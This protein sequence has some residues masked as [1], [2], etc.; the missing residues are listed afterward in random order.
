MNT[1]AP[2]QALINRRRSASF[3]SKADE[4]VNGLGFEG[5]RRPLRRRPAAGDGAE[6]GEDNR[7]EGGPQAYASKSIES[8]PSLLRSRTLS[9]ARQSVNGARGVSA[10]PTESA[11]SHVVE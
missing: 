7:Y 6:E 8:A 4:E 9:A 11:A 1:S 3:G 2:S 10:A 5:N